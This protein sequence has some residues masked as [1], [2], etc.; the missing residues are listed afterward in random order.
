MNAA[1]HLL[2]PTHRS[3][4]ANLRAVLG[5]ALAL[6]FQVYCE[7]C[8]FLP[9][10]CYPQRLESDEFDECAT[11]FYGRDQSGDLVGYVRLVPPDAAGRLPLMRN[12]LLDEACLPAL[13]FGDDVC[14]VSRLMLRHD[15]RRLR[16]NEAVEKKP[17]K[18]A[19][20]NLPS[21]GG[22]SF[23]HSGRRRSESQQILLNLYRQMYL[24]SR[25]HR[26][27]YWY[28]AM[29]RPLARSLAAAGFPFR[30]VGPQADY[31]GAVSPYLADLVSLEAQLR[32]R[33][34]DLLEWMK[35]GAGTSAPCTRRLDRALS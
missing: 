16:P 3:S 9:K 11:H 31:Y 24:W 6:R 2:E 10:E 13:P 14:E 25:R 18:V 23:P 17:L 32:N 22:N 21:M 1:L 33:R 19:S 5:P 30:Q 15:Y 29:E 27:R 20:S 12:C 4:T 26:V 8:G 28:A 7:E 34:P 35:Q